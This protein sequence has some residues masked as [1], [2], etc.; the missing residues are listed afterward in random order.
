MLTSGCSPCGLKRRKTPKAQEM[1]HGTQRATAY[2]QTTAARSADMSRTYPFLRTGRNWLLISKPSVPKDYFDSSA[3]T[4]QVAFARF[5]A[6]VQPSK[7]TV[8]FNPGGPGGSGKQ[9]ITERDPM[10]ISYLVRPAHDV[11]CLIFTHSLDWR[12][13]RPRWLRSERNTRYSVSISLLPCNFLPFILLL[14]T[15]NQVL[16]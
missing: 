15:Q 11:A 9:W 7:G 13:I 5:K 12:R 14:Q 2:H 1:L 6:K 8:F 16:Q 3:G 4:A 10:Q